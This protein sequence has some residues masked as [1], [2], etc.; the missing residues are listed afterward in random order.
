MS[1]AGSYTLHPMYRDRGVSLQRCW[2]FKATLQQ[3]NN[4]LRR[5]NL[6]PRFL[7][8]RLPQLFLFSPHCACAMKETNSA[9]AQENRGRE[10]ETHT[11]FN[12]LSHTHSER[13]GRDGAFPPVKQRTGILDISQPSWRGGISGNQTWRQGAVGGAEARGRGGGKRGSRDCAGKHA[14][15]PSCSGS[16]PCAGRR[17]RS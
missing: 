3:H 10:K 7:V 2:C 1:S 5:T 6:Q 15:S 17:R 4:P 14:I 16:L 11:H 9:S 13:H 12:T 8:A